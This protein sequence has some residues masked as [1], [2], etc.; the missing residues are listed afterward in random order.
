MRF[1]NT[2]SEMK[3]R[4][5]AYLDPQT[6]LTTLHDGQLIY[7]D[8]ADEQIAPWLIAQGR[9]ESWIEQVIRRLVRPADRVIEVGANVG[10]YTLIMSSL[11]G[12]SGRLDAFE[13]NPRVARLLRRSLGCSG[14]GDRVALHELIV[15]DRAGRMPFYVSDRY[16]GF[17]NIADTGW[18]TGD[19]TCRQIEREAV[20]LDDVFA[21]QTVDFIRTDTEG[22]ELLILNGA[23][24]LLRRSDSVK[25]CIEWSVRMMSAR[26]DVAALVSALH[27]QGFKFW[28]IEHD[29]RLTPVPHQDLLALPDCEMVI[30]RSLD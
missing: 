24:D 11:I 20:R 2:L 6:A 17:G 30:A 5:Y 4:T 28:R 22:A 15:A 23:M 16:G 7:V 26:G 29:A 8:P 21:G 18:A 27:D 9:W 25:L 13:A 10:Y 19:E 12:E 1:H 14:R 3:L